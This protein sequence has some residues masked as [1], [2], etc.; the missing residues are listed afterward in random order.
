M[1]SLSQVRRALARP[2]LAARE[3]NRLYH[4]R[5]YR[6]AYN[7]AGVDVFAEDWDALVILDACRYDMFCAHNALDGHLES[8]TSRG[9]STVEFLR[10]NVAGRDLTDTVYVT[11]NPQLR[12]H[13]NDLDPRFH[14]VVDVWRAD[15]WDETYRTVLPET[16]TRY[17]REAAERFPR[18]RLVV[19]YVQPHYPF[20]T[21]ETTFDKGDLHAADGTGGR[22]F[23]GRIV[24]GDLDVSRE[25]V[26]SL[27]VANLRRALD[28]VA[29][30]LET[31]DG[32][33]VVTSD[34]GNAMG[35]RVRPVP[36]R[37]W[38]HPRGIYAPE[39]VRV[40]WLV[41]EGTTRR[42]VTADPPA[43]VDHERGERPASDG[44]DVV[45]DRLRHLGYAE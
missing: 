2:R 26:W 11:A 42:E 35:E 6:R 44:A 4:R 8:R 30:F 24:E 45:A 31:F 25:E 43:E 1:Y 5:G 15:G 7:T 32:R 3:V 20:L 14:R 13:W 10:G 21:T 38:G 29:D 40:P 22:D 17:A 27:S 12:H 39:L 37:E 33:V 34:H 19:H 16:T 23:W 18:K 9:S 41:R 36:V 28:S